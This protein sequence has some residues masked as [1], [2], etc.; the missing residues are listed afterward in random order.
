[1]IVDSERQVLYV[2]GGRVVDGD[3]D[4]Y[5][6]AGLYAYNIKTGRWKLLQ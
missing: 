5:K 3:W 4:T 6:Y 1:M 2:Y